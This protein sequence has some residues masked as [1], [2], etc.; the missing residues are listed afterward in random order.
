MIELRQVSVRAGRFEL[1]DVNLVVSTGS[2]GILMGKTGSGKTTL[3]EAVCGLKRVRRGSILL[4]DVDVTT[5]KPGMRGIGFVPQDGALFS[6]MT[7]AD[8][9][10]FALDVRRT[11]QAERAARVSELAELL[12]I[13]HLLDR[14]PVGLSGGEAQRVALGRALSFR[15]KVLCLDEPLSALD[16]E[17]RVEMCALLGNLQRKLRV[18]VL[19]ITHDR[20]E[21]A[22]LADCVYRIV[23]GAVVA[24][25][26]STAFQAVRRL[27]GSRE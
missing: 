1:N 16:H 7:V 24:E 2:Y 17:T 13:A 8:Q 26:C 21:A 14:Y 19:H 18:T 6:T 4:N 22:L 11:G 10:G 20:N 27:P 25:K 5:M 15:P 12:G 9:L 23:D 3:L